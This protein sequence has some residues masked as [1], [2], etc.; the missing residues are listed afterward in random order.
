MS[1]VQRACSRDLPVVSR[2]PAILTRPWKAW[3]RR[4]DVAADGPG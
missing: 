1:V 2:L 4:T 3:I